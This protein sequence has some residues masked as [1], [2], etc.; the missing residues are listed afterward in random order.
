MNVYEIITDRILESL[1]SGT[2]PWRC[3]WKIE[4]PKNVVSGREYRG[5][6]VL[7]LQTSPHPSPWW[8]T[9]NQ[10]KDLGGAVKK[11]QRGTP[12]VYFKSYGDD[13]GDGQTEQERRRFVLRYFTVF[14][15][16]QTEGIAIPPAA[17]PAPFDPIEAC[18]RIVS[19]YRAPPSIEHG[20]GS[21]CYLPSQ[22][23]IR[24]PSR[25]SFASSPE[26]Y[27]TIFH[28]LTHSS[29]AAH[30]LARK[31]VVDPIR[32]ASHDYSL[33]ELIAECGSAFLAAQAGIA[34][35]TLENSAAYI[36]SWAKRLQSE[37]RW[38]VEASGAAAKA[39]DLILGR[40]P[41][42]NADTPQRAA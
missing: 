14:N 17:S 20:G 41:Q 16:A 15:L 40:Q 39:A 36:A 24:M 8:V 35:R 28:E 3:P 33:E 18:E 32:F 13:E 6:N 37:P 23:R 21:A 4:A 42:S 34:N 22:D 27:S 10:A 25:E 7:L 30:R 9:F 11:G 29:G 5:V 12:V 2:V 19:G 31:G 38:I 26:Y 1:K